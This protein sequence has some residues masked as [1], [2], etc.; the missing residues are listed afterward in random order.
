M[1]QRYIDTILQFLADRE[2]RPLKPKQVARQIGIGEEEYPSFR[3]AV[4]QLRDSGRI[5]M[6][7]GNALT[8]PQLGKEVIGKYRSNPRGFGFV[9]PETPNA[10]GD[11]FIPPGESGSAMNGD[12]VRASV[13]R[14]GQRD[15][16]M[17]FAGKIIE[18]IQRGQDRFVGTLQQSGDTWFVLPEGKGL[19]QPAVV[20]DL[21]KTLTRGDETTE[22]PKGKKGKKGKK[23]A[24]KKGKKT[25]AA[26]KKAPP[27]AK[28]PTPGSK[29]VVEIVQYPKHPNDLPTG[30]IVEV[31]CKPGEAD[32]ETLAIIRAHDLPDEFPEEA[33]ADARAATTGF[34]PEDTG[35]IAHREDLTD[36]TVITVDPDTARDF[37]D[38]ISIETDPDGTVTLGVHIADVSSFVTAGSE[39]DADAK[40]R[41]NS[42]YFPTRV[43]P[44]L[45]EV[46]SNG[47]CSLQ[48]GEKRFCKSAFI[49]YDGGA[50]PIASKLCESVIR[51]NKRLT[52]LQAQDIC[53]GKV[54]GYPGEVVKLVKQMETLARRIEQR[55]REAG[56][57]H[58]DLPEVEL[59][60]DDD[61]KVVDAVEEDDAYTHTIIE[62]FM[63]EAN[64]AVAR[65][66]DREGR[67]FMRRIHP[68]PAQ[69]DTE[70]LQ[71][72]LRAF[73]QKIPAD[74]SRSEIQGILE[75]VKD[76]PQ[77][78]PVNMAILRTFQSAEYS[79]MAVEHF[80]LASTHYCHFTSPIRR[81][82]DLTVHRLIEAFCRG[83]LEQMP[84]DDIAALTEL[85]KHLSFTEQRSEDAERELRDVLI[86]QFLEDKLGE[87]FQGVITGVTNFGLF[88]QWPQFL[89]EGLIRLEELGDDWWE[90]EAKTGSVRG[91]VSGKTY[92]LG[93]LM[94][95][96]I[97]N[98]DVAR[99]KL[100][101]A[102]VSPVGGEKGKPGR[103]G[104]AP[105][106]S[107]G[108]SKGRSGGKGSQ[109]K[110]GKNQPRKRKGPSRQHTRKRS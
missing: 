95:V 20:K 96:R 17:R 110:R 6:G 75:R 57:L 103:K 9:L 90:V 18:V 101:L 91:E 7:A 33:I 22:P 56:M 28:P 46:L 73:G 3:E 44:M 27:L 77:S 49:K 40:S 39:L 41:G 31:L 51:S 37:D 47:V 87:E 109:G 61:G 13:R 1:P 93:D 5:V 2:G 70:R 83:T 67:K 107:K 29:V 36:L 14:R 24:G 84:S 48:E 12:L 99:R 60:L 50:N 52:Y 76:T 10:H 55:R 104:K 30:V 64:E 11:L 54:G 19:L 42:T 38:A 35:Q 85:G 21:P 97:A 105:K 58:L 74:L 80:A 94:D 26:E 82:A 45:P 8:L 69:E 106:K 72:F 66:L 23:A 25:K 4:K 100:D 78:F 71:P 53:D 108:K 102:P 62:M 43:V 15:G 59:V 32:V 63:V 86:L 92:R 81:Y 65:A 98:V 79:P 89:A 68:P 16:E 34:D 88:V